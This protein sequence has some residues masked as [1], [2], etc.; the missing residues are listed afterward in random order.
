MKSPHRNLLTLREGNTQPE[1]KEYRRPF[2]CPM[3]I[4]WTKTTHKNL[5]ELDAPVKTYGV[6][7]VREAITL[8]QFA[9]H[10]SSH[11]SKY[12]K[13][14][15][16]GVLSTAAECLVEQV[17]AGNSVSLGEL[18]V[19]LPRI[20]TNGVCESVEDEETGEKPVFTAADIKTVTI[21][22]NK[23]PE[24]RNLIHR[25]SFIEVETIAARNAALKQKKMELATGTYDPN[26]TQAKKEEGE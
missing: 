23:G 15:V 1:R 10:I 22:W 12:A 2:Y 11:N 8:D 3:A 7:Q 19:F 6:A 24:L 16:A 18:G 25:C 17:M 5:Q 9:K 14:D 26:G 20:R 21:Y 4:N 13:A